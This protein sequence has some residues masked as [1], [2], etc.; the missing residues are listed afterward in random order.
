M[1]TPEPFTFNVQSKHIDTAY[2]RTNCIVD[3]NPHVTG[4]KP[5]GQP[6]AEL[7]FTHHPGYCDKCQEIAAAW[8]SRQQLPQKTLKRMNDHGEYDEVTIAGIAWQIIGTTK[9]P[10]VAMAETWVLKHPGTGTRLLI[11]PPENIPDGLEE[12]PTIELQLEGKYAMQLTQQNHGLLLGMA[13]ITGHTDASRWL[14]SRID[15]ATNVRTS[16]PLGLE[17]F[18]DAYTPGNHLVSRVKHVHIPA[19]QDEAPETAETKY[20]QTNGLVL[21]RWAAKDAARKLKAYD[22]VGEIRSEFKRLQG[23]QKAEALIQKAQL[24]GIINTVEELAWCR[25]AAHRPPG[26]NVIRFEHT[27]T[28]EWLRTH[29]V[30]TVYDL[31]AG[32]DNLCRTLDESWRL[33][34]PTQDTNRSRWPAKPIWQ[35]ITDF[36]PKADTLPSFENRHRTPHVELSRAY[37]KIEAGIKDLQEMGPITAEMETTLKQAKKAIETIDEEHGHGQTVINPVEPTISSR[38]KR[39]WGEVPESIK[40]YQE[41]II[42]QITHKAQHVF[43]WCRNTNRHP[44]AT[45]FLDARRLST[46]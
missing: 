30:R 19:Y 32:W 46:A 21:L 4:F 35:A 42:E 13:E 12:R 1:Y 40:D 29:G 5:S 34:E 36:T 11:T 39:W 20:H 44:G 37:R 25:G 41:Y 38:L 7:V 16:R 45:N 43:S 14:N 23:N 2:I 15:I 3:C 26:Y 18:G 27:I 10:A 9:Q 6:I 24:A 31:I 22:K 8:K 33:C 17:D 28:T